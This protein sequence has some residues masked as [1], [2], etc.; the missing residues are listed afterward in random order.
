MQK[1]TISARSGRRSGGCYEV[2]KRAKTDAKSDHFGA[3]WTQ[4]RRLLRGGQACK[5]R[6]KK[7]P[8]RR[9]LGAGPE[10]VTRWASVQ[11][12]MQK[13]TISARSGR[14]S[15]GCYEVGKRAKTDA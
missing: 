13:A 7:R 4:V 9:G 12:P 3:V 8:F 11:K 1:A 10:A 14:R 15:G 2:G 6:C 5:N